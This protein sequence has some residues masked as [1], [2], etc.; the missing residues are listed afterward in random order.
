[1]VLR[2]IQDF[3]EAFKN[4]F[5][6]DQ[7]KTYTYR[8]GQKYF[9]VKIGLFFFNLFD[10][11]RETPQI[12]YIPQIKGVVGKGEVMVCYDCL[13]THFSEYSY[14]N[15]MKDFRVTVAPTQLEFEEY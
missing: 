8:K 9:E 11:K 13:Q 10:N 7:S 1:M 15:Q 3:D 6:V 14:L 2:D 12:F 5:D 4:C